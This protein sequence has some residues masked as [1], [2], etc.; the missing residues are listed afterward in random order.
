MR[1]FGG[2]RGVACRTGVALGLALLPLGHALGA[3][4]P[5][6]PIAKAPPAI[7]PATVWA[8]SRDWEIRG[9]GYVSVHGPERET[10]D[11]NGELVFAKGPAFLS[12]P[13]W[14]I[15]RIHVGGVLNLSDRTNFAYAGFLWTYD[16][17]PMFFGEVYFGA[18]VHDGKLLGPD[19][20]KAALGCRVLSHSGL[21]LG[22]RL[23]PRWSAMFTF[24]HS[25]N[26]K[27]A[28][29]CPTNQ[30]LNLIGGRLG[31]AF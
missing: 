1:L 29:G 7:A 19:P 20:L 25:S 8:S 23:A 21:N 14:A 30:S 11:A 17:T 2:F 12:L 28:S 22:V 18:M 9:G 3:D 10:W 27:S 4:L 13:D 6:T 26:G 15:P 31:Y 16:F 24:D 5:I